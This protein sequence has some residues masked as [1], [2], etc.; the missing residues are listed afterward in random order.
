M[1]FFDKAEEFF[2]KRAMKKGKSE[3][4]AKR[5]GEKAKN[6]TKGALGAL[7]VFAVVGATL[8]GE[9][10]VEHADDIV[11]FFS[12][13]AAEEL[14]NKMLARMTELNLPKL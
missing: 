14:N 1:G 9:E 4:E 8:I 2:Y 10:V 7:G 5:S 12:D 13:P 11:E 3:E 6:C